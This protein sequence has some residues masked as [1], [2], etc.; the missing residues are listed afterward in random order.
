MRT[1]LI[2]L[3]IAIFLWGA[4]AVLGKLIALNPVVLVCYRLVLTV[5]SLYIMHL[6]KPQLQRVTLQQAVSM[7]KAGAMQAIHWVFF[8][9]SVHYGNA[10]VALVC[11]SSTSLFTLLFQLL[12]YKQAIAAYSL[13]LSLVS[14]IGIALLFI[15]NIQLG[16]GIFYGILSAAFVA[17]VAVLNKQQLTLH[18]PAT[19]TFYTLLGGLVCI[20]VLLPFYTFFFASGRWIPTPPEWFWLLV[21]SWLCT[22]V[23]WRL[24]MQALQVVSAYTQNLLLNLEPLYGIALAAFFLQEHTSYNSYFYLGIACTVLVVALQ[25]L[26]L[27]RIY[28]QKKTEHKQ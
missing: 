27:T 10:A 28:P 19:V 24:S 15:G 18:P 5:V 7:G 13:L 2:Q 14:I 8:F 23:T 6:A 22:I 16:I 17:S 3:H 1:A 12:L 20:S 9:A 26:R 4:T 21:L 25:T 11:L